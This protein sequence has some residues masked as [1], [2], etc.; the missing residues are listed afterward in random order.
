VTTDLDKKPLPPGDRAFPLLGETLAFLKD[1]F[2][3]VARRV[4]RHGPVFRTHLLGRT[5]VILAG[6]RVSHVFLDQ[7]LTQREGS[8]PPHVQELFG[9]R[10]LPTLDGDEHR[11]RKRQVL[12]AFVR[13]AMP[14]Y[15]PGMQAL[16][17]ASLEAWAARGEIRGSDELQRLAITVIARNVVSLEAGPDLE[18][19]LA[20]FKAVTA[21][22][23]GFPVALPGTAFARGLKARDAIFAILRR[24]VAEHRARAS[25]DPTPTPPQGGARNGGEQRAERSRGPHDDGLAR[26]LAERGEDGATIPDEEAAKELH[27]VFIAGYIVYA[28][29]AAL[30][31]RLAERPELRGRLAEEVQ[32]R[33]PAGPLTARALASMP[34]LDQV[35]QETKRIT[36]V[37]PIAFGRARKTF[38]L[39]GYR[40]PEGTMLYWAPW[41]HDQDPGTFPEP[42]AFDVERFSEA[43]AEHRRHEHAFAPQGLGPPLGHTCPGYDYATLFMQVFAAVVLRSWTWSFPEQDM[44]LD[45]SKIPPAHADGLRVVF[46]REREA[47]SRAPARP[48]VKEAPAEANEAPSLGPDALKALASVIWADGK[49]TEEEATALVRVARASGLTASEIGAVE[50][51]TRERAPADT[52]PLA[53]GGAAAEHLF[54]L[55]CLIA[56]SDGSVDPR[57]R[58]AI[59]ALGDRLGLAEPARTR[60]AVASQAVA[61][62]IGASANALDALAA[63]LERP[64]E[65]TLRSP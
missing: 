34:L 60:A 59:A 58:A 30:L 38:E 3:F 18:V 61:Q 4:A 16:V 12:A 6:P 46:R 21:G 41:N 35:V 7:E 11:A 45:F 43:R 52:A 9:G 22:F 1:S 44:A 25:G 31:E 13:E 26:I 62:A 24:A 20:G 23:A 29:L 33:A 51:A 65:L 14:G 39:E 48:A 53:L 15:V 17:E 64:T 49:M 19:L 37:V 27:H 5:T 47:P 2:A 63:E 28:E 55:A 54:A 50:R 32:A 10:S 56:A 40:I 36:P 57:E 42:G 8:M